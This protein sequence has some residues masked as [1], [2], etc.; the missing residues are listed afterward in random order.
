MK[1]YTRPASP[2]L[3]KSQIAA[4]HV[5]KAEVGMAEDAYRDLLRDKFNVASSTQL[6]DAGRSRLLDHFSKL[7]FVSTS[8]QKRVAKGTMHAAVPRAALLSKIDALLL[9][10]GRDRRYIEPALVKR[11]CK[12]DSLNFCDAEQLRK[13][14]AALEYD[15]RRQDATHA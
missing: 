6:D 5:A 7:G 15:A 2:A 3:R 12:L 4:I 13:L 14:V 9:S 11:I 1:K 10:R 8:R